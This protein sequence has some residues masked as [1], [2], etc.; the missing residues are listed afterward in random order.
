MSPCVREKR[1]TGTG[2]AASDDCAAN[3]KKGNV[4]RLE[5]RVYKQK[6]HSLQDMYACF[7]QN[8]KTINPSVDDYAVMPFSEVWRVMDNLFQQDRWD[9]TIGMYSLTKPGSNSGWNQIWQLGWVGGGQAT[10]PILLQGDETGRKRAMRN[11]D[12]IL[13]RHRLHPVYTMLMVMEKNSRASGLVKHS[14]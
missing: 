6:A 5:F 1:A 11:L 14:K 4:V 2:F 12:V 13:Q 7:L 10:L 3:L 8:R 9:E